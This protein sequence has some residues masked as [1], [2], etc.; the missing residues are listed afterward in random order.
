MYQTNDKSEYHLTYDKLDI[1]I[2]YSYVLDPKCGA[3]SMFSGTTRDYFEDK[4]VFK[5]EYE[6]HNEMALN[7]FSIIEKDI[8]EQWDIEKLIFVHRLGEVEICESSVFIAISSNHRDACIK[9][10]EYAI[11]KI[12]ELLP[13]WKKEYYNDNTKT[14]KVN[15]EFSII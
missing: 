6:A 11:N 9:A 10:C 15:K 7:K 13:I 14:W 1:N 4:E 8:R 5:L 2:Y 12:K 3:I